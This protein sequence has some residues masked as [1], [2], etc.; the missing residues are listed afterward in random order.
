VALR[1]DPQT[2][3][4]AGINPIPAV[5]ATLQA[6][7]YTLWDYLHAPQMRD[8]HLA[9]LGAPG[10][11]KTTL[12]RHAALTMAAR[13]WRADRAVPRRLPVLL[14]LRDHAGA[15]K[16]N[17]SLSLAQAIHD[18]LARLDGPSVPVGWFAR[19]LGA[20][21]CVVL[22]DGLDEVANPAGGGSAEELKRRLRLSRSLRRLR[23]AGA[24]HRGRI[25][26]LRGHPAGARAHRR[27]GG[28]SA[29]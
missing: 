28:C 11:G 20:G 26:A 23:P 16:E 3:Q 24:A 22:L 17:P 8:Q 13:S 19:Q 9:I 5:P 25:A 14:F 21:R 7:R 10:S 18:R 12:L 27:G 15:I 2:T 1:L 4:R 29:G 6:G